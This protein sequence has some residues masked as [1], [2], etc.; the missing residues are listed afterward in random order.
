[1]KPVDQK[2]L[3]GGEIPGDCVRACVCSI[4]ELPLEEVPHFV[5]W[6]GHEWAFALSYWCDKRGIGATCLD[7]HHIMNDAPYM[8]C[9]PSPRKGRHAV[10]AQ[11][12]L[13]IHD[14]HPSRAGLLMERR[15]PKQPFYF[16]TWVFSRE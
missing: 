6:H 9:G 11:A 3:S 16:H 15:N 12:G 5:R 4:L 14:P 10:V 8:L 7:G 1:M 13:I 2:Y